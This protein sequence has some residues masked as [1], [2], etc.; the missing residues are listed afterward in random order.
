MTS[1]SDDRSRGAGNSEQEIAVKPE[2][3]PIGNDAR[4][5]RQIRRLPPDVA[6][7]LCGEQ[8]PT[9]LQPTTPSRSVLESHHAAGKANDDE[10]LVVL[11]SNCH[12]KVTAEQYDVGAL[13]SGRASSDLERLE[14]ALRSLG[15]FFN[16]LAEACY[17]WAAWITQVI[18]MLNER[19]PE[20]RTFL[21]M[22]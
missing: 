2:P 5:Q 16:L 13:P 10:L 18:T 6:C 3:D 22:P 21:D 12:K 9:I 4:K 14:L 15:V 8:E 7:A 1:I 11:C 19:L 20:W 17:R